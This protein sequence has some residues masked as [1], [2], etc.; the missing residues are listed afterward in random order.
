MGYMDV[1]HAKQEGIS[2]IHLKNK[3]GQTGAS[4]IYYE[5]HT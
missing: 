3:A 1:F 2:Y 5:W 4:P